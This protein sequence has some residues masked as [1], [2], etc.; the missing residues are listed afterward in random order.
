MTFHRWVIHARVMDYLLC[1]WM[2]LPSLEGTGHGIYSAHCVWLCA[3]SLVEP[4]YPG[5]G[6][7]SLFLCTAARSGERSRTGGSIP[8]TGATLALSSNQRSPHRE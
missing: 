7:Q 2:A 3:C 6:S 5:A 8:P 1:G 4:I